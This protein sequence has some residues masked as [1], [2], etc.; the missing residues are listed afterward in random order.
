MHVT[1]K[2][3][4]YKRRAGF[5]LVELLMVVAIT[6]LVAALL[7]TAIGKARLSAMNAV[8]AS[9]MGSIGKAIFIY[10]ADFRGTAPTLLPTY[11]GLAPQT[12]PLD[13]GGTYYQKRAVAG[14]VIWD[15]FN[16]NVLTVA[17][18]FPDGRG[19]AGLGILINAPASA[20]GTSTVHASTTGYIGN[21]KVFFHPVMRDFT[22]A[23]TSGK[24]WYNTLFN[25]GK[26]R[27]DS[28][29]VNATNLQGNPPYLFTANNAGWNTVSGN[30]GGFI[31]STVMYRGGDW[32]P[33]GDG[34]NYNTNPLN[35]GKQGLDNFGQMKIDT[36]GFN[37]RI[38]LMGSLLDNQAS[39]QGGQTDYMTGDGAV[40]ITK[41][42]SFIGAANATVCPLF[43]VMG[44]DNQYNHPTT[45]LKA[46][47]QGQ[48]ITAAAYLVERFELGLY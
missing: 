16:V 32:T 21:P 44:A 6:A 1:Q 18:G 30:N 38:L 33:N 40:R 2:F 46:P 11:V 37:V 42:A 24:G 10:S 5:T 7:L 4:S 3:K 12:I 26:Y 8:G 9:D 28:T 27:N 36:T 47:A 19:P 31:F 25:W 23:G 43:T 15:S 45:G 20:A 13:P 48:L 41:N 34:V 14:W 35:G 17:A 22:V 39:R 29:I